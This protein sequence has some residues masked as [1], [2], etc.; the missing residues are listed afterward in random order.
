M[1]AAWLEP[2]ADVRALIGGIVESAQQ[3]APA[4]R[5]SVRA[6]GPVYVV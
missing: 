2:A 1:P 4:H 5:L 6:P 3:G